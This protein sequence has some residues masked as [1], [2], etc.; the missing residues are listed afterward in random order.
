MTIRKK[1]ERFYWDVCGCQC[2]KHY[3]YNLYISLCV[4]LSYIFDYDFS[5]FR[6]L[7]E[8]N[9]FAVHFRVWS[10]I[11]NHIITILNLPNEQEQHPMVIFRK[12]RHFILTY[13]VLFFPTDQLSSPERVRNDKSEIWFSSD[14]YTDHTIAIWCIKYNCR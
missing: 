3:T 6:N 2:H 14:Y 7:K 9:S 12:K 1:L 13:I 4:C 5:F 11:V 10:L 8:C